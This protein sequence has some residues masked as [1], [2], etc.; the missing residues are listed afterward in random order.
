MDSAGR[1]V[2]A[3]PNARSEPQAIRLLD[4]GR[5]DPTFGRS[6][7][8]HLPFEIDI[9]S[10]SLDRHGR[11]LLAGGIRVNLDQIN[12]SAVRLLDDGSLDPSFDG[13]G[14]AMYNLGKGGPDFAA[15]VFVDGFDRVVL[16]GGAWLPNP[17]LKR[18]VGRFAIA[19]LQDD[20][21]LDGSFGGDGT[22]LIAM[23]RR[24][25]FAT[26]TTLDEVANAIVVGRAAPSS[27]FAKVR[28]AGRLGR[29][30]GNAGR[31]KLATD[32]SQ[33]AM[34]V[35]LDAAGRP[36]TAIGAP[37]LSVRGAGRLIVAR[38]RANGRPDRSFS[39]DSRAVAGFGRW[40][41][42][43]SSLALHPTGEIVVAGP[44]KR[45]DANHADFAAARFLPRD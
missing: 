4:D 34:D 29:G 27:G 37:K 26:A 45:G 36:L 35:E 19:R 44:A 38:L 20:G 41:A 40:R 33:W 43:A 1:I 7:V 14:L 16:A 9:R 11:I 3:G 15:D 42:T 23:N 2:V 8:V 22:A 18:R 17:D 21:R 6:G 10:L 13:D 28:G 12:F 32:G 25:S 39:R 24:G 31:A 5:I 30:F